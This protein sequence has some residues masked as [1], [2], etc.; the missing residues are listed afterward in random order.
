MRRAGSKSWRLST[1]NDQ[2]ADFCLYVRDAFSLDLRGS[3]IPPPLS[4]GVQ[5]IELD[6]MTADQRDLALAWHM[7]WRRLVRVVG[8][9]QLGRGLSSLSSDDYRQAHLEARQSVMDPLDGFKSLSEYP[10][11]RSAA[12]RSWPQGYEWSKT[13]GS[14]RFGRSSTGHGSP[15]RKMVA[16]RVIEERHVS[17]E[18]VN[19]AVI[20]LEVE[21]KWFHLAAPGILLCSEEFFFDDARF[22]QELK[23]TFESGLSD[24]TN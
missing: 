24:E 11:L 1:S 23:T 8:A 13:H 21:G 12:Q 14:S 15:T 3:D 9:A 18:R 2:A 16:E 4:G 22:A 6:S 5:P 10:A 19:A 7:W 17:P 20:V